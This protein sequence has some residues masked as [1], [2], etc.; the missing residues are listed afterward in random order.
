MDLKTAIRLSTKYGFYTD[1]MDQVI[2][3]SHIYQISKRANRVI[4]RAHPN[5]WSEFPF[6]DHHVAEQFYDYLKGRIN[7]GNDEV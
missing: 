3:P 1:M 2:N 4:V 5:S 6:D 7:G